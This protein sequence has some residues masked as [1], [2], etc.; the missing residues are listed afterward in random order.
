VLVVAGT[1]ANSAEDTLKESIKSPHPGREEQHVEDKNNLSSRLSTYR[2]ESGLRRPD[3]AR[4]YDELVERLNVI[5]R[6]EVG[7]QL[8]E[9]MPQFNLPDENG[10]L[11][12]LASL[13]RSGPVVISINRGHWCPYCKL[14]LR[15]LAEINGE[16][17]RLGA[18]SIAIMPDSAEFTESYATRNSL[19]FPVLSDIDLGY[20]LSLD[21]I[22]WVG[23]QIGELYRQAGVELEKYHGNHAYFL[24]MASKFIVGRDG[25]VKARQV[26]IEFR[27]R[28]EP[29]DIIAELRKLHS[30]A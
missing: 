5:D 12:A 22:F 18:R 1:I 8:G 4:A 20:S 26:N 7:P 6:G 21:L 2:R 10:R 11:V 25:L 17:E 16:I 23:D 3:F 13:L 9:A 24:P 14:D 15:S 28:M 19:P 29:A 30:M 27:E